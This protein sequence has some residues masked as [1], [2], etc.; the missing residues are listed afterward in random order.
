[1]VEGFE[2]GVQF[3]HQFG[4]REVLGDGSEAFEVREED[5]D[6]FEVLGIGVAFGLEFVGD[7]R[8]Q[9]VEEQGVRSL[10]PTVHGKGQGHQEEQAS[11]DGEGDDALLTQ[12]RYLPLD[13]QGA[14]RSFTVPS[15][16]ATAPW[17]ETDCSESL[18]LM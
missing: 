10:L 4:R 15:Y 8:R 13:L 16:A 6:Q 1:M 7:F 12:L 3:F 18:M 14:S 2:T 9:N 11:S 5:G 17:F